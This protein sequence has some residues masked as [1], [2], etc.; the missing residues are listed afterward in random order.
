MVSIFYGT[1]SRN[2]DPKGRLMLPKELGIVPG[3]T[4]YVM[5]GFEGCLSIYKEEAFEAMVKKLS[6]LSYENEESRAYIRLACASMFKMQL[7]KVG[8][9]LLGKDLLFD[10]S[11]GREVTL[12]GVLDH[13]ELWDAGAYA[14]YLLANATKYESLAGRSH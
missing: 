12:I 4:L 3:E 10:Y 5:K 9:V 14:K 11:I 2:L 13:L 6:S 1:Y 7:D 8:R